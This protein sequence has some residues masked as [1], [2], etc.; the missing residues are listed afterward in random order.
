MLDWDEK[1]VWQWLSSKIYAEKLSMSAWEFTDGS[2]LAELNVVSA[3]ALQ[4]PSALIPR[5]LKDIKSHTRGEEV[6]TGKT[7]LENPN[8]TATNETATS[9]SGS[10]MLEHSDMLKELANKI[11]SMDHRNRIRDYSKEFEGSLMRIIMIMVLTY[12]ILSVYMLLAGLD[13]PW[14]SAIVPTVGFQ[15]STVSLPSIKNC[16]VEHRLRSLKSE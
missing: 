13:R 6:K 12:A 14:I 7:S 3:R 8:E 4:V 11:S 16:Y 1:Q 15:L 2:T 5:L 9:G 10:I